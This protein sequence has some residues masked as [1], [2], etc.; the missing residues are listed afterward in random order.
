[1][2]QKS[3][4]KSPKSTNLKIGRGLKNGEHYKNYQ[5]M[6]PDLKVDDIKELRNACEHCWEYTKR[7][8]KTPAH[9]DLITT[10]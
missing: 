1:M 10:P 9:W 8:L 4:L 7:Q 6:K 5:K 2:L 3:I